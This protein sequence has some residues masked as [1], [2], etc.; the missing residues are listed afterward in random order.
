MADSTPKKEIRRLRGLR[1][2]CRFI[3]FKK[4]KICACWYCL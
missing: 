3:F 4:R 2:W 1:N